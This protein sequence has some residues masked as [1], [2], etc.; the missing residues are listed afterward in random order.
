MHF[1]VISPYFF[2]MMRKRSKTQSKPH[3]GITMTMIFQLIMIMMMKNNINTTVSTIHLFSWNDRYLAVAILGY[4]DRI[5]VHSIIK[6]LILMP[7][8]EWN[9]Y[10]YSE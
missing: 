6:I 1:N 10:I 8:L 5:I 4:F 3:I 2:Q 9:D 7:R